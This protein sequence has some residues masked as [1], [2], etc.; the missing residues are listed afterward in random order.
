[1]TRARPARQR[2][3]LR[4][5]TLVRA[6]RRAL[7]DRGPGVLLA[8]LLA[9]C[10]A[11]LT[12][13]PA[14]ERT[15]YTRAMAD[16]LRDAAPGRRDVLLTYNARSVVVTRGQ[17]AGVPLHLPISPQ[18][19]VQTRARQIMGPPAAQLL[20][21][22][23][24]SATTIDFA[25]S[26]D[27]PGSSPIGE[28]R[29]AM[30]RV[31]GGLPERVTWDSGG[32]G[33]QSPGTRLYVEA[34]EPERVDRRVPIIPVVV[35]TTVANAWQITVGDR[36]ELAPV[37]PGRSTPF[38]IT[39]ELTGTYTPTDPLDPFW[40]DE[41]RL[42]QA[43]Q[44]IAWD[45]GTSSRAAFMAAPEVVGDLGRALAATPA[46]RPQSDPDVARG[47]EYEW[48]YRVPAERLDQETVAVI[49]NGY[50]AMNLASTPW[51]DLR[52]VIVSGL[53]DLVAAHGR[54]VAVTRSLVA[55]VTLALLALGSLAAL[56]IVALLGA[57]RAPALRLLGARGAS[58]GQ[59]LALLGL[60]GAVWAVPPAALAAAV[61]WLWA[62][63]PGRL[64]L[65]A[66]IPVGVAVLGAVVLAGRLASVGPDREHSAARGVGRVLLEVSILTGAYFA[67]SSVRARGQQ[68]STGTVDWYAALAP[69][70][71][72]AAVAVVLARILPWPIWLVARGLERG[73]SVL[74]FLALAR[75][76]R[77]MSPTLGPL[78]GLVIAAALATLLGGVAS[79]IA[80]ERAAAA[81]ELTGADLRIDAARVTASEVL[82]A[83]GR[84]GITA[85]IAAY[86]ERGA[87][88]Q[89]A[90]GSPPRPVT[91]IAVDPAAYA[92]ALAGTPLAFAPAAAGGSA[93]LLQ[94]L[95]SD[96]LDS[97]AVLSVAVSGSARTL[98]IAAIEPGLRR[99]APGGEQ[100]VLL[101]PWERVL[102]GQPYLQPNTLFVTGSPAAVAAM[103]QDS[104]VALT[105][106]VMDRREYAASVATRALPT[107]VRW[108]VLAGLLLAAAF[109]A[110]ALFVLLTVSRPPRIETMV[111]LRVL[112]LRRQRVW[113]LGVLD[114]LPP[115]VAAIL[116]G[117]AAGVV[118]PGLMHPAIDLAPITGGAA[119]PPLTTPAW[120]AAGTVLAL[121]TLAG[122]AV[123]M[124]LWRAR[125][126][127]LSTHLRA[128]ERR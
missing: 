7:R 115:A 125:R 36:F 72:A 94:G 51:A 74:G 34:T 128:G 117:A 11:F 38:P 95:A 108:V 96:A 87:R 109:S 103:A 25:L 1:M 39:V 41:G 113:L 76:A 123:I 124:D 71:S 16:V 20:G 77:T 91:I 59:L 15:A 98:T 70:L 79:T 42:L 9:L 67:L 107:L 35:P 8:L 57:R 23:D 12:A 49:A 122:C 18:L 89:G 126:T 69:V 116:S 119:H 27:D 32:L 90:S 33:T 53:P 14:L 80:R 75:S 47:L 120:V 4:S 5:L 100:P 30:V 105:Q 88:L 52:P 37:V 82:Q 50:A 60:E 29:L 102:G 114:V 61:S 127:S 68:I 45:G 58:R 13:T 56:L 40:Q 43:D 92:D 81:Y 2:P 31:Q 6:W 101:L 46:V 48:R 65:L 63:P 86:V 121:V 10:T 22:P 26:D 28:H 66:L 83:R 112:G 78:A 99:S 54:A 19:P 73:R 55:V 97:P 21:E 93:G 3:G 111:R 110:L 64:G 118:L 62:G 104:P 24:F 44:V 106:G 84:P 17:F 85:A